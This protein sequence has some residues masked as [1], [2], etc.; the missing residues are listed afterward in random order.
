MTLIETLVLAIVEGLTEFL[1]VSS[2]GHLII[3]TALLGIEPTAFVKLFTVA[4]Q[5][6]TILS[7]VFLY[8]KRFFRSWSFYF[9]LF[10]AFL[11]AAFFG[12]L[13]SDVIDNMLESP[14]TV[15]VTLVIGGIVLLFVDKWFNRPQIEDSDKISYFTALKI[16]LFQCLAMIP[17]MSRS[18]ATIVGGMAQKLTRKAAAEFSF[19]LAVPTMFGATA[20]KLLDFYLDGYAFTRQEINVLVVGN[21]IGFIVAVIAIKSFIGYVTKYGFKAFGWYRIIVGGIIIV[22]LLSGHSLAVL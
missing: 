18:G 9:K 6:G 10:V 22:M 8:Y 15:A 1:P 5:L 3:A 19:F 20:K 12:L 4:I 11:P 13:L 21:I 17:G 7:V 16:G 14:M 2:T